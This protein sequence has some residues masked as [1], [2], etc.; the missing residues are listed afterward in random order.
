VLHKVLTFEPIQAYIHGGK[1]VGS[2]GDGTAQFIARDADSQEKVVEIVE[3]ELGMSC[4]RLVLRSGRRVRKAVIPAAGFGTRLFPATK[5]V[6]KE[7]F[8]VV[9]HSGRAKPVILSIVEEALSAGIEE[10][11]ILVQSEDRKL[12]EEIFCMPPPIEHFNRLSKEDQDYCEYLMDIGHRITFIAQDVQEG[13]GHA[14]YCAR[15]W[16]GDEPFLLLLGDHLYASD[17]EQSCARQLLNVY[18]QHGQSVVGVKVTP[19]PD[20][21]HFGCVTG[22]WVDPERTLSI[23]EFAEKPDEEYARGHLHVDGMADDDFLTVFGQYV[24]KPKI[25]D[26]LEEHIRLNIRERGEFQLTSCLDR[27]RQEDGFTGHVV[28]GRRFD[29]GLPDAYRETLLGFRDA[30]PSGTR[31]T[32]GADRV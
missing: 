32:T 13:F 17:G 26:Y 1:G 2:Q 27:L 28:Q 19:A 11:C 21:H 24:L 4:L 3:R 18:E 31:G 7:L 20:L 23:T 15:E 10:V 9:D 12:F 5:A 8:P 22:V 6:K 14:V 30:G 29:I 16:V 25:F